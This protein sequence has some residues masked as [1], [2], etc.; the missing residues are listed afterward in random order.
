MLFDVGLVARFRNSATCGLSSSPI[1]RPSRSLSSY[2]SAASG[3]AV[4]GAPG[5]HL[6][7]R[8]VLRQH[9][10]QFARADAA[11]HREQRIERGLGARVALKALHLLHVALA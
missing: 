9:R 11:L 5:L 7:W 3:I 1:T 8:R 10:A 4:L 6:L 2:L